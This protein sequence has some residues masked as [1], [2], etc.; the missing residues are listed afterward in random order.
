MLA[1]ASMMAPPA[2]SAVA[3]DR[4]MRIEAGYYQGMIDHHGTLTV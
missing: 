2:L 1:A 4:R 3:H